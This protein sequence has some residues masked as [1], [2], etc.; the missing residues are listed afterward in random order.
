MSNPLQIALENASQ[1][2]KCDSPSREYPS[3]TRLD[4]RLPSKSAPNA[5][6]KET[7][8][9]SFKGNPRKIEWDN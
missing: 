5:P 9:C 4:M 1:N 2:P 3:P 6:K 8:H 7:V